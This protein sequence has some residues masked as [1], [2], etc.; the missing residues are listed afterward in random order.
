MSIVTENIVINGVEFVHTYSDTGMMIEREG[1]RYSDAIDPVGLD[2]QYT[3]TDEPIKI[4]ESPSES[5]EK[6]HADDHSATTIQ[7]E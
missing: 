1:N 2:R 6:D 7:Q 4:P 3:E 5:E